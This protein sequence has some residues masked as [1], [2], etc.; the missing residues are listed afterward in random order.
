[1]RIR[2]LGSAAGGGFPQWNCGC[3]NCR[4][5]RAGTIPATP[6]SQESVAVSAE[7]T[8]WLLLNASPE[9]R[10]QIEAFPGLHPRGAR[11]SPIGA[12]ALTNG[13][14][15]RCLGLFSLREGQ[16]LAVYATERVR[17][18]LAG[19]NVLFRAL[20][21]F[22]DQVRWQHLQ[23]GREEPIF[24]AEGEPLGLWI[25]AVA[26]PGKVPLHLEGLMA[27]DPEDNIGLCV[28]DAAGRRLAYLTSVAFLDERTRAAIASADCL[29][30]DGTFWSSDEL[31]A[32][33]LG[34][35]RAEEMAHLPVGGGAGSLAA[36]AD[37]RVPR[38][39][40][41]HLNNTNPLLREDSPERA[42]VRAAGWEVA[43]DGMEFEI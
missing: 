16:P 20:E 38:R 30:F 11:H 17:A 2:V 12:L 34:T 28:R 18:G 8:R 1:M 3:P 27:A 4:D 33:G 21:R 31:P 22:P 9:I 7:G 23:L 37:L 39:I 35:M 14:L 10:S 40:Y 13:D 29:F 41:S 19:R 42:A 6:R 24:D 5:A 26:V 25:E 43:Y 15:D 36:L 32:L